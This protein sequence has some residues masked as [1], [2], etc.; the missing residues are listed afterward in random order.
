MGQARGTG[1]REWIRRL[2]LG[3]VLLGVWLASGSQARAV[4]G[5]RHVIVVSIDGLRPDVLR[6]AAAP[7]VAVL[8]GAGSWTLSARTVNPSVTLPAHCSMFSGVTPQVHGVTRNDWSPGDRTL[9]VPTMFSIAKQHGLVCAA[10]VSKPKL[11]A[12]APQGV[13][14]VFEL[15]P[16]DARAVATR[17]A[18]YIEQRRPN[19]CFVQ[20]SDVDSTG[21]SSGWGSSAQVAACGQC[22]TAIGMLLGAAHRAQMASESLMIVTSDHGGHGRGHGGTSGQDVTV[23]WVCAGRGAAMRYAIPAPVSVC[24]TAAVALFGLG[25]APPADWTGRVVPGLFPGY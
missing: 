12:L 21:H 2:A 11:R 13:A 16:R 7:N 8:M 1:K 23:P 6:A 19:L 20:L 9:G 15:V 5:V 4:A 24:D 25:I 10:F 18:A 14:D 22:D 17:A 3:L